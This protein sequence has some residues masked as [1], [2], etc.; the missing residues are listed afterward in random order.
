MTGIRTS[1]CSN[2][3]TRLNVSKCQACIGP[4]ELAKFFKALFLSGMPALLVN[5]IIVGGATAVKSDL[6]K[7]RISPGSPD[8]LG[9]LKKIQLKVAGAIENK[10]VRR[11]CDTNANVLSSA[12]DDTMLNSR[13]WLNN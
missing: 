7:T 9:N 13:R 2:S 4:N 10:H 3:P 1:R 5:Y 8:G 6:M 11:I 12:I